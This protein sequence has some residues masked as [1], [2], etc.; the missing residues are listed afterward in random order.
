MV[1]DYGRTLSWRKVE[2]FQAGDRDYPAGVIWAAKNPTV[3]KAGNYDTLFVPWAFPANY[4][5]T[6]QITCR[7]DQS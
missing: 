7:G 5:P 3:R 6:A 2:F 4:R 1:L